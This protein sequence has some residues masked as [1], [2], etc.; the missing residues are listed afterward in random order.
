MTVLSDLPV[1]PMVSTGKG[2]DQVE[3]STLRQIFFLPRKDLERKENIMGTWAG[4]GDR[5]K[6]FMTRQG[7]I[8]LLLLS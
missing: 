2:S 3:S 1:S 6:M 5:V 7:K 4:V 8:Y